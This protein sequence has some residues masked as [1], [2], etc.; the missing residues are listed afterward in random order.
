MLGNV[1][2]W[3]FNILDLCFLQHTVRHCPQG[4]AA[5]S[6]KHLQS[7]TY[8]SQDCKIMEIFAKPWPL[9]ATL[10]YKQHIHEHLWN[11]FLTHFDHNE[12]LHFSLCLPL[13]IML[14]YLPSSNGLT[15]SLC[16]TL[17]QAAPSLG[18]KPSTTSIDLF[19]GAWR[20]V[21]I[22]ENRW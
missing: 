14:P 1:L 21:L 8:T 22:V 11:H 12:C 9:S 17:A 5:N 18:V 4:Y 20:L 13:F 6:F 19:R 7:T 10:Q 2:L 3:D 16:I 15:L